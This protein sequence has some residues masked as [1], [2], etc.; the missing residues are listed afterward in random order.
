MFT[1]VWRPRPF[2][3]RLAVQRG[4]SH[5]HGGNGRRHND[6]RRAAK[7]GQSPG[8][9]LGGTAGGDRDHRDPDRA[10]AAGGAGGARGG[11]ARLLRQQPQADRHRPAPV[12][13]RPAAMAGRLAGL[14]PGH[15]QAA[16]VLVCRAGPGARPSCRT[17]SRAPCP[18]A[19]ALRPADDRSG[20]RRGP[21]YG[22]RLVPMSLG[23][24]AEDVCAG[25]RR[26]LRR[27]RRLHADR[28]G[29]EQLPR[30]VRLRRDA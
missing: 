2:A 22:D 21:G 28:V 14:R 15:G 5:F 19:G 30:R 6:A 11:P 17:W 27:H 7:L 10:V 1:H 13:R 12:P 4:Q 8:V 24:R 20:Q 29:H 23:H 3:A 26:S 18:D 25:G 9:Y 16:L